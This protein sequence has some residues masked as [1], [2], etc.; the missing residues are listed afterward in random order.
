M[1]SKLFILWGCLLMPVICPAQ[2]YS[3]AR[4]FSFSGM[5]LKNGYG[6]S[7]GYEQMFNK[8]WSAFVLDV[9]YMARSQALKI[10]GDKVKLSNLD[11]LAGYRKY[12]NYGDLHPYA[13]M[14]AVIGYERITN[15]NEL[16]ESVLLG[17]KSGIQY[18]VGLDLGVEY[19]FKL[20]SFQ[21][22]YT[23]RYEFRNSGYI[24][25]FRLGIK[26]YLK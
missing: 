23:P 26:Y 20:F 21:A 17:R 4:D 11:V 6:V 7:V 18:G 16:P 22:A 5:V 15:K 3:D 8:N 25:S 1:K 2:R 13:G 24:S 10:K 14:K 9:E 12:L 19:S